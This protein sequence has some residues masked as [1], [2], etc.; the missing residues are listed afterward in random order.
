MLRHFG[1]RNA[2]RS[3]VPKSYSW[4][5]MGD[6]LPQVY[7]CAHEARLANM[8][9]MGRT[10]DLPSVPLITARGCPVFF[11]SPRFGDSLCVYVP[12]LSLGL[13]NRALGGAARVRCSKRSS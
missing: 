13:G 8:T 1:I 6:Q 3:L 2:V 10:S 7:R 4:E 12:R 5:I 11:N 9:N